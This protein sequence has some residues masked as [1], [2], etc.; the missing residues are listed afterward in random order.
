L[1]E[2]GIA[3]QIANAVTRV[4]EDNSATAV[5]EITVDIGLLSG[6]DRDSLEFCF[7]AITRGTKLERARLKVEEIKPVAVCRKCGNTYEVRMD[8]FR[9]SVCGSADFSLTAGRDI[10]IR[11]VEVE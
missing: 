11:Q 1:H 8:D 3:T 4:M 9:C 10:S 6:V 7:E 5:G 2:L